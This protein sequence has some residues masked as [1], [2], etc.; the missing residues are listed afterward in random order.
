MNCARFRNDSAKVEN[1][2]VEST[3]ELDIERLFS[4]PFPL[5][6][7]LHSREP[8]RFEMLLLPHSHSCPVASSSQ[9][10]PP[11][12]QSR[13]FSSASSMPNPFAPN[14]SLLN[15]KFETYRLSLP[16]SLQ[17]HRHSLPGA[18]PGRPIQPIQ[19]ERVGWNEVRAKARWN[20]LSFAAERHELAWVDS[21]GEVWT[22][23]LDEVYR[24]ASSLRTRRLT[25][26][27]QD[28]N[29]LIKHMFTLPAPVGSLSKPAEYPGLLYSNQTWTISD[30]CGRLYVV[31]PLGAVLSTAELLGEDGGLLPFKLHAAHQGAALVSIAQGDKHTTFELSLVRPPPTGSPTEPGKLEKAWTIKGAD[32]PAYV[33]WDAESVR[34]RLASSAAYEPLSSSM[35]VAEPSSAP[36]HAGLGVAPT[37]PPQDAPP[38]DAGYSWSQTSDAVTITVPLPPTVASKDIKVTFSPSH[39]SLMVGSVDYPRFSHYP[40]WAPI[41]ASSSTWMFEAQPSPLLTI[42]LEKTDEGTRW[43]HLFNPSASYPD[44]PETLDQGAL[45]D[46]TSSLDK[47]VTDVD[48]DVPPSS[49]NMAGKS[50]LA[51]DEMDVDVDAPSASDRLQ[52]TFVD[53]SGSCT[54]NFS[55]QSEILLSTSLPLS[56][57]SILLKRDVDAL[58]FRPL[59][60]CRW[61]HDATYPALAFVLASKR[62]L[63]TTHHVDS[64]LA[65]ALESSGNAY[66]YWPPERGSKD[67]YAKSGV[68]KVVNDD[69]GSVL[70]V[71][72]VGERIVILCER[73]LVVFAGLL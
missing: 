41:D 31:T 21:E 30:G 16:E 25:L 8:E 28:G 65:I 52:F 33:H 3:D 59:S 64:R 43:P 57:G 62:S 69:S 48:A 24:H 66:L 20:H 67:K 22:A 58:L 34:W 73:E 55:S 13:P 26:R 72:R 38:T 36:H 40:V 70:G 61:A 9:A 4:R 6:F 27:H 18:Q 51:G 68:I 19:H 50:T 44:V 23:Q 1:V 47:Y 54:D 5:V 37:V 49:D 7:R 15:A 29:P 11:I 17:V 45:D 46:I 56:D 32:L 71:Q 53:P 2:K 63:R 60:E 39:L 10:K 14:S 12:A 42:H 35:D